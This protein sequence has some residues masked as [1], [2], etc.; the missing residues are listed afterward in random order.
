MTW[1]FDSDSD[2]TRLT[3][4][5]LFSLPASTETSFLVYF[6]RIGQI[7]IFGSINNYLATNPL[8]SQ[9]KQKEF[10]LKFLPDE[11]SKVFISF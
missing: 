4:K 11:Y 7:Y 3:D 1:I 9:Q 8:F 2:L 6:N 5:L 10:Q